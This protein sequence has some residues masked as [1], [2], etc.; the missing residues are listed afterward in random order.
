M[1]ERRKEEGKKVL[2]RSREWGEEEKGRRRREGR[3]WKWEEKGSGRRRRRG[4]MVSEKIRN[5][6]ETPYVAKA[7]KSCLYTHTCMFVYT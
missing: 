7:W 1:G 5:R 2:G 6:M 4:K 3:Y